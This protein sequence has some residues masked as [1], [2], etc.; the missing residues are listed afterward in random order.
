MHAAREFVTKLLERA[1][2][3]LNVGLGISGALLAVV[4]AL[5]GMLR[6]E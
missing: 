4:A 2:V 3:P 1:M 5:V 6:G